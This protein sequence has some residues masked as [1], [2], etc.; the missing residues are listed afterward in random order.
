MYNI[1]FDH[2]GTLVDTES[3]RSLFPGIYELIHELNKS[4]T[5]LYVWTARNRAST[6]EFL[7]TL[8]IIGE[9]EDLSTATD[10][11]PKPVV[12]GLLAMLPNDFDP[13]KTVV[14]GDSYTDMIGAK[15]IGALALGV[16]WGHQSSEQREILVE[17]GADH[18][19][20]HVSELKEFLNNWRV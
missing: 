9:F 1:V 5:N 19:F 14:I 17:F 8:G 20:N 10:A 3:S 11:L 13:K 6:V 7:K 2:D 15:K 12:D 4:G 18:I 16:C